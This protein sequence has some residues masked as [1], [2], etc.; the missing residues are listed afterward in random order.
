MPL[1]SHSQMIFNVGAWTYDRL[2]DQSFWKAHLESLADFAPPSEAVRLLDVGCGPGVSTFVLA[3]RLG[4]EASLVGVDLAG[5]MVERAERHNR[6]Q[7]P[8]LTNITFQQADATALSFGDDSFDMVT[9]HSFL[10]LVPDKHGVLVELLRVLR[11][12]GKLVFMEPARDASLLGAGAHALPH[13]RRLLDRPS[14]ASRFLASMV[15][16]RVASRQAGRMHPALIERLF[17]DAGFEQIETHQ[18]LGGLS[19]HCVGVKPL[20]TA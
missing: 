9:G 20:A 12:G 2:T 1:T 11:P 19:L 8:H 3:E 13:W 15:L 4:E 16:W 17:G 5:R 10:Y 18:N 7:Y 6:T 14:E